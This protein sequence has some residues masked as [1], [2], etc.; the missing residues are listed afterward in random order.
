[1]RVIF[2]DISGTLT[3]H[4]WDEAQRLARRA[5][6]DDYGYQDVDP[7]QVARVNCIVEATGAQI[8]VS[9]DWVKHDPAESYPA[10]QVMLRKHGLVA[11]FAG[12]TIQP[13]ENTVVERGLEIRAWLDLHP[14]VTGY[15][16]LD[17]AAIPITRATRKYMNERRIERGWE[18]PLPPNDPELGRHFIYLN[19][20]RFQGLQDEHVER[21]IKILHREKC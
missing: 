21:A 17:D 6:A 15:V 3:N 16:I 9:S 2:L 8:V 14:E 19:P 18:E 5:G 7:V 12:H 20:A 4:A 13:R 11:T 10:V 1:M